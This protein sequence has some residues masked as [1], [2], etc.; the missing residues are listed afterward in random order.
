MASGPDAVIHLDTHVVAWLFA[1]DLDQ[2]SP[3]A[4]ERLETDELVT[5]PMVELELQYLF[6]VKRIAYTGRD[7]VDDLAERVGLTR[8]A[9]PWAR[10]VGRASTLDWTRDPFDRLITANA[11]MDGAQLLTRDRV[12][13]DHC[14]SAIWDG[15][16]ARG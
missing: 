14:P 16:G 4:L 6:E 10:V 3:L 8:S 11:L 7:I 1:R 5:S 2:M 12:I 15:N 13:R 9:T